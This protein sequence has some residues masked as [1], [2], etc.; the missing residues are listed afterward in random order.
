MLFWTTKLL[1]KGFRSSPKGTCKW[2]EPGH[3]SQKI[4]SIQHHIMLFSFSMWV[5]RKWF[6]KKQRTNITWKGP[7][8][9]GWGGS[10]V[11]WPFLLWGESF[12]CCHDCILFYWICCCLMHQPRLQYAEMKNR[13]KPAFFP[14]NSRN[15]ANFLVELADPTVTIPT[16]YDIKVLYWLF[17]VIV[18][19][20]PHFNF[21]LH[22]TDDVF[23]FS[24]HLVHCLDKTF[25]I[26]VCKGPKTEDNTF[27]K[28]K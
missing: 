4:M 25:Q 3:I 1:K 21:L 17:L 9:N 24:Y 26:E 18:I 8:K 13:Q 27:L 22:W 5:F 20:I 28:S 11:S 14:T 2:L 19:V 16:K 12:C 7:R 15:W 10:G 23:S 6:W